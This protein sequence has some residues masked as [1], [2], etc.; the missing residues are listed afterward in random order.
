MQFDTWINLLNKEF[1]SDQKYIN[2]DDKLSL[3]KK[4]IKLLTSA[5][6]FFKKK[7]KSEINFIKKNR[8][9]PVNN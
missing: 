5:Q 2:I 7:F 3:T 1:K 6:D 8:P 4:Q 9:K